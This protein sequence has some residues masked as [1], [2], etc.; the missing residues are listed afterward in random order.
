MTTVN[1]H[2]SEFIIR[3]NQPAH[4]LLEDSDTPISIQVCNPHEG[5][6]NMLALEMIRSLLTLSFKAAL[7]EYTTDKGK[8]D[9]RPGD[10]ESE[11]SELSELSSGTH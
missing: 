9:Q 8:D 5:R 2:P 1:L 7:D 3:L 4:L 10:R 11:D 6:E